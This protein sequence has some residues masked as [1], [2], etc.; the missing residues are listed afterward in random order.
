M[1][2][3]TSPVTPL[4]FAF[5]A[6]VDYYLS[7]WQ[8]LE[9]SVRGNILGANVL[10]LSFTGNWLQVTVYSHRRVSMHCGPLIENHEAYRAFVG[11]HDSLCTSKSLKTS[12]SF[13]IRFSQL[14][15]HRT[16]VREVPE[17]KLRPDRNSGSLNN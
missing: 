13:C 17:S 9:K 4:F 5:L 14:V 11:S 3:K 15:E 8:V 12:Q 7:A 10:K 1:I 2:S 6:K 16:N